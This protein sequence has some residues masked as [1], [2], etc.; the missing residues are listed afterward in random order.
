MS[1]GNYIVGNVYEAEISHFWIGKKSIP[2][3]TIDGGIP[4]NA[5]FITLD[6]WREQ[7]LNQL[8]D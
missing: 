1:D 6:E 5:D 4:I 2:C 7:Q 8:L 3:F